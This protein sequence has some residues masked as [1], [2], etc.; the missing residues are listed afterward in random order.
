M[1]TSL[2]ILNTFIPN[3]TTSRFLAILQLLL[4][5]IIGIAIYFIVAYKSKTIDEILGKNAVQKIII[6][7]KEKLTKK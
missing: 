3:I 2:T 5:G 4:Y 1:V 6:N 7:L